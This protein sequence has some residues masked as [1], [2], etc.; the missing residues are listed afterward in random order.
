MLHPEA[1]REGRRFLFFGR[2]IF[3]K[4][5]SEMLQQTVVDSIPELVMR[6]ATIS[7][8]S[9]YN[10]RA[11]I[12]PAHIDAITR[13][14]VGLQSGLPMGIEMMG[15]DEM[16]FP[17]LQFPGYPESK[18]LASWGLIGGA[19]V[20]GVLGAL[21]PTSTRV[22]G[23][24]KGAVAGLLLGGLAAAVLARASGLTAATTAGQVRA[25][26]PAAK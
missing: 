12:L 20:G 4:G 22:R 10:A 3:T 9:P 8:V 19:A 5:K 1:C 2:E 13:G 11:D 6:T 16:G 21:F 26:L 14:P 23:A 24:G 25:M 17:V 18:G 15:Y 7:P